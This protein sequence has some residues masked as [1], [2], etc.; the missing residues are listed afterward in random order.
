MFVWFSF[1]STMVLWWH[2]CIVA[3]LAVSCPEKYLQ[4][5]S[6]VV[7]HTFLCTISCNTRRLTWQ[8]TFHS[9]D[10]R[11]SRIV[12]I[13]LCERTYNKLCMLFMRDFDCPNMEM[14]M[15][16]LVKWNSIWLMTWWA[17]FHE[18]RYY[19][20]FHNGKGKKKK[21]AEPTTFKIVKSSE[22]EGLMVRMDGKR[23]HLFGICLF[24]L[25]ICWSLIFMY[26]RN[27]QRHST[28]TSLFFPLPAILKPRMLYNRWSAVFM[29]LVLKIETCLNVLWAYR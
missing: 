13:C 15:F 7:I 18:H 12:C 14:A 5:Q 25:F 3:K 4:Q 19:Y 23:V 17:S 1:R 27:K 9:Y 28:S 21:A 16:T 26:F 22:M 24:S 6:H 8:I 29:M 10:R 11:G 20:G 2:P